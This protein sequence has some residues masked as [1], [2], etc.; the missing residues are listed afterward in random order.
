MICG[1]PSKVIYAAKWGALD[2]SALPFALS[3]DERVTAEFDWAD[4]TS[5][6]AA[7]YERKPATGGRIASKLLPHLA[8]PKRD[9]F[10]A[11]RNTP[12]GATERFVL[13]G[14]IP[15]RPLR[16]IVRAAP[17]ADLVIP[18]SVDGKRA[19]PLRLPRTDGW[20]EVAID[21]PPP[22]SNAIVVELGA[23][24]ERVLYHAWAVQGR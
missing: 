7:A 12:E 5:E 19:D 22:E 18:V 9:V 13:R 8:H 16:L 17:V 23:S 6:R 15:G 21:L 10:D 20:L 1:A 14:T 3:P 11:G 4:V 2:G 24:G